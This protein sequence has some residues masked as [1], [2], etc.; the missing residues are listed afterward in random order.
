MNSISNDLI[1]RVKCKRHEFKCDYGACIKK[2]KVC[3]NYPHCADGSDETEA[4]CRKKRKRCLTS[5]YKCDSGSCISQVRKNLFNKTLYIIFIEA[6][7][8]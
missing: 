1:P 8:T 5:Q 7:K 4:A 6:C 3:D 2:H